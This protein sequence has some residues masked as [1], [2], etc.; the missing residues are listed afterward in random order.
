MFID[1]L[2]SLRCLRPHEDTW[3]VGSFDEMD[4]RDVVR[5]TLGCPTC[6]AEYPV[7]DG[8]VYF[9]EPGPAAARVV[10]RL[11]TRA[12]APTDADEV[13]RLAAMLG[14]VGA[15][16]LVVLGGRWAA[17]APALADLVEQ[18][19]LVLIGAAGVPLGGGISALVVDDALPLAAQSCRA[20]ALD[21]ATATPGLLAGAARALRARGRLVAPVAAPR[22]AGLVEL[23]RDDRV[24]VAERTDGD[25]AGAPVPLTRARAPSEE[26]PDDG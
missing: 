11:T 25:V 4:G 21:E 2:D 6:R 16:G 10:G 17:L 14:L 19:Q 23:A 12:L 18:L 15:G 1:L 3:L 24:W 7:R 5:G 20:A 8:V 9:A 13:V 22:P 26:R